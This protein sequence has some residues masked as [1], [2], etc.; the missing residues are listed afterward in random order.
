MRWYNSDKAVYGDN[1][2]ISRFRYESDMRPAPQENNSCPTLYTWLKPQARE[3]MDPRRKH[4]EIVLNCHVVQYSSN[5]LCLYPQI[6]ATLN[7]G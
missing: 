5:Y 7:F 3:A 2:L 1:Q 6:C 4:K